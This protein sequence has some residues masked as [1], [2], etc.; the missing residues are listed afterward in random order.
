[1]IP[2]QKERLPAHDMRNLC[3]PSTSGWPISSCAPA[4]LNGLP[5]F[6]QGRISP[7]KQGRK[8]EVGHGKGLPQGRHGSESPV[9]EDNSPAGSG[10]QP[11]PI[12][13][14]CLR[15]NL[16]SRLQTCSRTSR[17]CAGFGKETPSLSQQPSS[18]RSGKKGGLP[19]GGGRLVEGYCA[20]LLRG[21]A[22][23]GAVGGVYAV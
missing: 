23:D 15:R 1:M 16:R 14:C 12:V 13:R 9:P 3:G 18:N 19:R 11:E 8:Q 10:F 21:E 22:P 2:L 5:L 7:R 20:L 4:L 17:S 6:A